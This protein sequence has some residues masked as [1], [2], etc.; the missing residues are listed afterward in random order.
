[1]REGYHSEEG[2]FHL[3]TDGKGEGFGVGTIAKKG[4]GVKINMIWDGGHRHDVTGDPEFGTH[5]HGLRFNIPFEDYPVT[6]P[7]NRFDL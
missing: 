5:R 2:I 7:K 1:M 6:Q 4:G 3:H